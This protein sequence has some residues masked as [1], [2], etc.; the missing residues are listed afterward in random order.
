MTECEDV[1]REDKQFRSTTGME[2]PSVDKLN[3]AWLVNFIL[4]LLRQRFM[5][6]HGPR[7][8]QV[9]TSSMTS[10]SSRTVLGSSM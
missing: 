1:L 4:Q 9:S 2:F 7:D 3:D 8:V 6:A 10:C 5:T